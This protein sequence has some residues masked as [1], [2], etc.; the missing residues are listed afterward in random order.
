MFKKIDKV[1]DNLMSNRFF[2]VMTFTMVVM[3]GLTS[4]LGI[5]YIG[6][7]FR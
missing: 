4:I 7:F 6:L 5:L 1:T 2:R 3:S